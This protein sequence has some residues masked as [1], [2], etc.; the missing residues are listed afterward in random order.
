MGCL[1]LSYY[2]ENEALS[3]FGKNLKVVKRNQCLSEKKGLNYSTFGAIM[4]GRNFQSATPYRYS[5]QGQERDDEIKGAGNSINFKFRMYDPRLGRFFAVDPLT[6]DYPHYTPYSFSG[7]KV[8][9][10][11]EL[12]GL[13]EWELAPNVKTYG[14]YANKSAAI[15]AVNAGDAMANIQLPEVVITSPETKPKPN[16]QSSRSFSEIITD[17]PRWLAGT[18]G[19]MTG[20]ASNSSLEGEQGLKTYSKNL[21]K[22]G[23]A[24][25]AT[26]LAPVGVFMMGGADAIDTGLDFKNEGAVT[27]V[28]NGVI[29]LAGFGVGRIV[30]PALKKAG[31]DKMVQ[32]GSEAVQES[33][34]NKA[35]DAVT[36]TLN[37]D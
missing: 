25:T 9:S 30:G 37:D 19:K 22:A 1:K 10:A 11:I 2:Q 28:V 35:T 24:L 8:I 32:L 34:E 23:L 27:G 12:E 6:S 33:L 5:F 20:S 36:E 21:N 17:G 13:E 7:N 14:P 16:V 26:P 3:A 15:K 29:R 31:A 18:T 4:P